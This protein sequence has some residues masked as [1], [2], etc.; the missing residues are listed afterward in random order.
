MITVNKQKKDVASNIK[1]KLIFIIIYTKGQ[2][3]LILNN[4]NPPSVGL[5]NR[6]SSFKS[7]CV[8][9]FEPNANTPPPHPNGLINYARE[10]VMSMMYLHCMFSYSD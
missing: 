6:S 2:V 5:Y 1:Y 9:G 8:W 7:R 10:T 4:P 3:S